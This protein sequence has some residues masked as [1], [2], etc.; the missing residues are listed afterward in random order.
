MDTA[1]TI[2]LTSTKQRVE[3]V[4]ADMSGSTF[5]DVRLAGAKFS[6]V[7]LE[8]VMIDDAN[9]SGLRISNADMRGASIVESLTDGM[10][11]NGIAVSDLLKAYRAAHPSAK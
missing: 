11:I 1:E 5:T 10:T 7:N 3:A 8:G 9:L 2:K 6:D 4:D